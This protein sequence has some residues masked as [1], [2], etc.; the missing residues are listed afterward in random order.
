[1]DIPIVLVCS[2]QTYKPCD[3]VVYIRNLN[4]DINLVINKANYAMTPLEICQRR[5]LTKSTGNLNRGAQ[6]SVL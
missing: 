4:S 3:S 1:M 2:L 5:I 6:K